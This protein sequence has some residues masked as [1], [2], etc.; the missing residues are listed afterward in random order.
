VQSLRAAKTRPGMW[1]ADV[2]VDDKWLLTFLVFKNDSAF[3]FI[4]PGEIS[5][6]D[7]N[8]LSRTK[9]LLQTHIQSGEQ[10]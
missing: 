8:W 3:S 5:V 6:L 9:N 2:A 4:V 10:D 7:T 1:I